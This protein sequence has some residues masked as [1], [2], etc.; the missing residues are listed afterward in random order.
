VIP[1][2][3]MAGLLLTAVPASPVAAGAAADPVDGSP[4][5]AGAGRPTTGADGTPPA[6][7]DLL[8]ATAVRLEPEWTP[9]S[10]GWLGRF[11]REHRYHILTV[12]LLE[13]ADYLYEKRIG[14]PDSPRLFS[15]PSGLDRSVEER[16]SSASSASSFIASNKS[17]INQ[18]LSLS[19]V[20][21]ANDGRWDG[22]A[23]DV[24][25]LIE[26]H[27]INWSAAGLV[28]NIVGRRRPSLEA[29]TASGDPAASNR[30]GASSRNSFY[31]DAASSAFTYMA[32]TDSVLARRFRDNP[33]ARAWSAVGLYG[34]A[35]YVA[36]TRIEQGKHYLSDV[37][38]GAGAGILVGK[39]VYRANHRR[40]DHEEGAFRIQPILL[41]DGVGISLKLTR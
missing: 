4:F 18:L 11:W 15:S 30:F 37:I 12:F 13:Q 21:W 7:G 25:G 38:V 16:Y 35:G 39:S 3:F 10:E 23:D 41:P 29:A 28:K 32:Y 31:S 34:L 19:A 17:A 9:E 6:P 5:P 26:A 8:P 2:I 33:K 36:F 20:V 24:M 27:K 1:L 14:P 40:E 22:I